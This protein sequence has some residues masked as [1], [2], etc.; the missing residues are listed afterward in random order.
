MR[1]VWGLLEVFGW[2]GLE[3]GGFEEIIFR[4]ISEFAF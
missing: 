2:I 1:V 4:Y 3:S